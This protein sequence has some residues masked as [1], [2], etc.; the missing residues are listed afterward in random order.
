M[1]NI[2][3]WSLWCFQLL[4]VQLENFLNRMRMQWIKFLLIL[5]LFRWSTWLSECCFSVSKFKQKSSPTIPQVVLIVNFITISRW[6]WVIF[7][8]AI[9]DNDIL[10]SV[11]DSKICALCWLWITLETPF[12]LW[13]RHIIAVNE[14]FL[15][16]IV[17][18]LFCS[19][20]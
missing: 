4:V 15:H 18:P 7:L 8:S 19:W 13:S 11:L 20:F 10:T 3:I 16:I 17:I 2:C 12:S 5:H 9:S 14:F 1:H 6:S